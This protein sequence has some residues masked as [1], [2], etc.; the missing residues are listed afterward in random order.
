[1]G[2]RATRFE[3]VTLLKQTGVMSSLNVREVMCKGILAGIP[4]FTYQYYTW[5]LS[6]F[7]KAYFASFLIS[8]TLA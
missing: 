3:R 1:M 7:L 2:L 4:T 5:L 8:S 6:L